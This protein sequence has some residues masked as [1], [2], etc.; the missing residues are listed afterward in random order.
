MMRFLLLFSLLIPS[1]ACADEVI[2][3]GATDYDTGGAGL[4][5]EYNFGDLPAGQRWAGGWTALARA[6]LDGDAFIGVGVM[7]RRRV[8]ERLFLDVAFTPG[9]YHAGE[10]DLGSVLMFRSSASIG[11]DLTDTS[12]LSFGID[13]YSNA[14]IVDWNPGAESYFLRYGRR[15]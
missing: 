15:F 4:Q 5:I 8:G 14:D 7:G 3:G 1:A 2:I 9:A 6:D 11:Y 13:H 10:T 12:F